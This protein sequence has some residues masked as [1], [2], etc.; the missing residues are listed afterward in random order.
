MI[1]LYI[2]F[3]FFFYLYIYV[4]F[5]IVSKTFTTIET[6]ENA[7]KVKKWFVKNV[8]EESMKNHF[9]RFIS[10]FYKPPSDPETLPV[11]SNSFDRLKISEVTHDLCG[12][13]AN[14]LT[15]KL[16]KHRELQI[17]E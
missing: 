12:K 11:T 4:I 7:K 3:Q 9:R 5:I 16:R 6:L 10:Q 1:N 14:Y 17:L 15:L 8:N 13:F 2:K